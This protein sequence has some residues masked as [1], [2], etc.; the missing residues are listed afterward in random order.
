[1]EQQWTKQHREMTHS[2]DQLR[3]EVREMRHHEVEYLDGIDEDAEL[4]GE[5][6]GMNRKQL[7]ELSDMAKK[8][9]GT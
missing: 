2:I 4:I 9:A 6:G 7:R 1:M 8:F 5:T 3:K